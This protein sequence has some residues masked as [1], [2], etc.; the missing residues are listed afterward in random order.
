MI[1]KK[2]FETE[3]DTFFLGFFDNLKPQ[4]NFL[5]LLDN[6]RLAVTPIASSQ[7]SFELDYPGN[8][9]THLCPC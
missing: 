8:A 9:I 6:I 7:T 4:N 3:G 5:L 2:K 1:G